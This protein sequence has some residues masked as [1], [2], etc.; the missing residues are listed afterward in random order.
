[1]ARRLLTLVI[2]ISG[3]PM[4]MDQTAEPP[5]VTATMRDACPIL[6]DP[7]I[8]AFLD[9][10]NAVSLEGIGRDEALTAW[11]Q[12]C[13]AIPPDG[14]FGGDQAACVDCL[15]VLVDEAYP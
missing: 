7:I 13:E 5:T 9:A 14:N 6:N 12:S 8:Q 11:V 1:M 4:A 15:S 2:I 10:I 3:C